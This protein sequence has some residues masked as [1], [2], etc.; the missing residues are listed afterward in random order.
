MQHRFAYVGNDLQD[1]YG[2]DPLH[3]GEATDM[4]NAFFKGGNATATLN[5]L[6][7]QQDGVLVSDETV[8]DFQLNTG[9]QINLRLQS[10]ADHQ[11]HV[12]TFHL[13]GIVREFPT[14]PKDSFLVANSSYIAEQTGSN[15]GEIVLIKAA[16]GT[17]PDRLAEGVRSIVEQIP[18]VRV[19]DIGSTQRAISSSLTAVDLRGLTTLELAFAVLMLAGATGLVLALGLAER[20]RT[21]AILSALGARSNQLGS[22]LWSEGSGPGLRRST[23]AGQ[24]THGRL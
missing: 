3:I 15:T 17:S 13:I 20:R 24:N 5:A 22:F 18:A 14:A 9:D 11:Y 23:D 1:L 19:N 8:K 21:F 6:A 10:A 2:I 7:K 4:S 16:S 12:V